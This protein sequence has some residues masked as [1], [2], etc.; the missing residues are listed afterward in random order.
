MN[1]IF[2]KYHRTL[3]IIICLP[4]LLT[5]V[6]GMAYTILDEWFKNESLSEILLGIHTMEILHLGGI[7]PVLNGIGVLGLLMTGLSMTGLLQPKP[8]FQKN[9]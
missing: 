2:R 3:A 1:R 4:L 6:T 5:I 8:N 9:R 7:Y